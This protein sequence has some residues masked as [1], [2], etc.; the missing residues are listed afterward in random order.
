[1][2]KAQAELGNKW[3]AISKLL[4]GRY[5]LGAA[6]EA[7]ECVDPSRGPLCAW[8]DVSCANTFAR[9]LG[10]RLVCYEGVSD[11]AAPNLESRVCVALWLWPLSVPCLTGMAALLVASSQDG[12]LYQESL[13]Q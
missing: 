10:L 4:P 13:E 11:D 6:L 1:M 7:L 5:V 3:A 2:I 8:I 9:S 12:Q